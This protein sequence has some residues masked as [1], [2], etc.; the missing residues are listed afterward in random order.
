MLKK[1]DVGFAL[2]TLALGLYSVIEG[3]SYGFQTVE[4]HPGSGFF[5]IVVGIALIGFSLINVLRSGVEVEQITEIW[6]N[7]IALRALVILGGHAIIIGLFSWIGLILS[8]AAS[9]FLVG[10]TIAWGDFDKGFLQKLSLVALL[11]P[12]SLHLIFIEV[13]G[14]QPKVG[15]LGF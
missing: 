8:A 10:L 13:L 4:G 15:F 14:V 6:S 11:A 7:S 3:V 2:V 1:L 12:L 5:P 9:I